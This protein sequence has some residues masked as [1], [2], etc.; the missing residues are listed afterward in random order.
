M[1]SK[2]DET[3]FMLIAKLKKFDMMGSEQVVGGV[4]RDNEEVATIKD[5]PATL[6]PG[7]LVPTMPPVGDRF[8]RRGVETPGRI[9]CARNTIINPRILL[10]AN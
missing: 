1:D 4:T 7:S 5:E 9:A 8:M 3:F 10:P 2:D 6:E